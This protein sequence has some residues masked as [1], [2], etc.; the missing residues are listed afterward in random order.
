[1]KFEWINLDECTW[2]AKTISG[3]IVKTRMFIEGTRG[4]V[5]S[6]SMVFVPD[7]EHKWEIER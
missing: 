4:V 3:W 2:R 1:M 5:M 7:Q 6:E